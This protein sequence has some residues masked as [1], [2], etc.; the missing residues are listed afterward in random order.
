[1]NKKIIFGLVLATLLVGIVPV[2]SAQ[3]G[4]SISSPS[5]ETYKKGDTVTINA[6][7]YSGDSVWTIQIQK[8]STK[9]WIDQ[10]TGG[11]LSYSF[12]IPNTW[13][14][15]TY[16]IYV[17]GENSNPVSTTFKIPSS[18]L[19]ILPPPAPPA[20]PTASEIED[21]ST[22]DAVDAIE[23]LD[24][25]DAADIM[26]DLTPE[27][28]ADI[29]EE[30]DTEDATE[31]FEEGIA[32]GNLEE[33]ADIANEADPEAV[34]DILLEM[35]PETGADLVEEMVSDDLNAAAL[36]V[37]E[38][39]KRSGNEEIL[40]AFGGTLEGV[41]AET[42][43][44]L[45]REIAGLP[46]T[47]ST[48]AELFEVMDITKV[49][50]IIDQWMTTEDYEGLA[51]VFSYLSDDKL[52]EIFLSMTPLDRTTF[53]PYLDATSQAKLP[54]VGELTVSDLSITPSTVETGDPVTISVEISNDGLLQFSEGVTLK[55]DGTS[56][57][58]EMVTLMPGD[59]E[60]VT[61]T[62]S[63]AT[64]GTYSV[65]VEGLTGSFTVEEPEPEPEPANIVYHSVAVSPSSVEAGNP[66]TVTVTLDNT[67]ELI[68]TETVELYVNDVLEDSETTSVVGGGTDS[69]T[70][71]V[72]KDTAGSYTVEAGGETATFTVT[73]PEPE[74]TSFPV[75]YALAG[76]VIIAAAAYLYMQQQRKL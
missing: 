5:G 65:E 35:E 71:Q 22:A 28:A 70:F 39:V 60:T 13:S 30:L 74:P 66:V 64:S 41:P 52:E 3:T 17:D 12:V 75:T 36:R 58:S 61:W 20:P 9:V 21:M 38:A 45:F 40:A 10:V 37:E 23:S 33:F 53:Y 27:T 50:D 34:A 19:P 43:V 63:E 31:I 18:F 6:V 76:V 29:V 55:I 42:L 54:D 51:T 44:S 7:S 47:P 49:I 8:S 68:G 14:S 67:G 72:T 57:E 26:A 15:G 46:A 2:V 48:V 59:S 11:S 4:I 32:E 25:E 62:V 1:M 56:E 73:E 16:T 24:T 69:V